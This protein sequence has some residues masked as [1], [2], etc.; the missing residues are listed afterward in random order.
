MPTIGLRV[1][2]R[3]GRVVGQAVIGETGRITV[4]LEDSYFA[5]LRESLLYGFADTI[6][7]EANL[8]PAEEKSMDEAKKAPEL[9]YMEEAKKQ[10]RQY[11][12]MHL[13]LSDPT[14]EFDVYVVWFSKT[15]Q[16]WKALVSTT[17]PDKMYYEVTFNGDKNEMYIDAY[18]KLNN[19][20]IRYGV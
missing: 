18:V 5:H 7:V 3:E 17:L 4:Q 13:D 12:L 10:V 19:I 11:V 6:C 8:I 2:T 16:N 9:S 14:P 20:C 1:A 15:L